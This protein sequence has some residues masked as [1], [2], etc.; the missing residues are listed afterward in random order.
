MSSTWV[1][2][3]ALAVGTV[4]AKLVGPLALRGHRPSPRFLAVTAL[5]AP[6]ILAALVVYETF[7]GSDRGVHLDARAVGLAAALL[8]LAARAP[9]I[10]VIVIAAAA[11]ALARAIT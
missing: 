5:V 11:T 7:G 6:A 1:T 9:M 10:A 4:A 3:A 2:I 8:A